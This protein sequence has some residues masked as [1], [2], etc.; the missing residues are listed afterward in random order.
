MKNKLT[1]FTKFL[2]DL[3]F[4]GGIVVTATV[5]LAF[6]IYG[7]YNTHFREFYWEL[8]LLFLLSGF[9]AVMIIRYLRKIFSTVLKDD[10][11]VYENVQS[12]RKM[13][14]YSFGIALLTT[15]RV[16]LYL[17]PAVVIVI[18]TFLIA[19]LF[20]KVLA[21]VFDKAISYKLENDLTI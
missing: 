8:V 13:G 20:S 19:G 2:L 11:F 10:C 12:L 5:P 16:Y 7:N 18:I 14:T 15:G 3:M 17:T 1:V 6:R 4:Y 21:L 9:F